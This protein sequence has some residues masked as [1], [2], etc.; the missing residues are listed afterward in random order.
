M[1]AIVAVA[2]GARSSR[3]SSPQPSRPTRPSPPSP[4]TRPAPANLRTRP[5]DQWLAGRICLT[6][7]AHPPADRFPPAP[8]GRVVTG[9]GLQ[10]LVEPPG[11]GG[12]TGR[13]P[14]SGPPPGKERAADPGR[15]GPDQQ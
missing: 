4:P 8:V 15:I 7:P 12:L 5:P 9:A 11:R 14:Y 13:G 2:I 6:C 3:W 10:P 1:L